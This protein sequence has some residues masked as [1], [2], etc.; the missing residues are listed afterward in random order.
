MAENFAY[1]DYTEVVPGI[2]STIASAL[3]CLT[4]VM[5]PE[6]RCLRYIELVFYIAINDMMASIGMALGKTPNGSVA[7]WYQG[8]STNFNYLSAILWSTVITFQ[9]WLIVCKKNV[10]KDLTYA[11]IVCWGIP[12]L[13]TFLPLSTS[14]YA[15]PDDESNW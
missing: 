3:V 7:C 12:L 15:N 13:A 11:H 6:L 5:F 10:I 8:I 4:V 2:I 9:V 14:T 1:S